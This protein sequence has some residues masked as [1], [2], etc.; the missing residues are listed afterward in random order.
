MCV[1]KKIVNVYNMFIQCGH[2]EVEKSSMFTVHRYLRRK[3]K[4]MKSLVRLEYS[5]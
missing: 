4:R 3:R 5:V 2:Y 1:V